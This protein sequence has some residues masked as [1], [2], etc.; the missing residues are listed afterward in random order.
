M[1]RQ[2]ALLLLWMLACSCVAAMA[3]DVPE[4]A[5]ETKLS[6]DSDVKPGSA[7][8]VVLSD[9]LS[10]ATKEIIV[11]VPDEPPAEIYDKID[12][13]LS[14][15]TDG[16]ASPD[17]VFST[18]AQMTGHRATIS[19]RIH[20]AE[21][22]AKIRIHGADAKTHWQIPLGNFSFTDI[23]VRP[24]DKTK[25]SAVVPSFKITKPLDKAPFESV[26]HLAKHIAASTDPVEGIWQYYDR[27]TDPLKAGLGGRYVI[28]TIKSDIGYDIVYISGAEE[29]SGAWFPL[30]IKGYLVNDGFDGSFLL[31]WIDAYGLDVSYET[32]ATIDGNLMSLAFPYWKST[33]R[34]VRRQRASSDVL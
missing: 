20:I 24:N 27:K 22:M 4:Y 17:T 7:I 23:N 33:L 21:N 34:F 29:N 15:H 11:I 8:T 6:I 2:F 18:S 5:C 3:I 25:I 16:K 14:M 13:K 26:N 10:A 32:S 19:L 12:L 30:A 1:P 28:A 9:S 31:K